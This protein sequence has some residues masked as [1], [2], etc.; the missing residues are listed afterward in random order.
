MNLK[1]SVSSGAKCF[2]VRFHKQSIR[3]EQRNENTCGRVCLSATATG[4]KFQ[5]TGTVADASVTSPVGISLILTW[6]ER[7]SVHG[8]ECAVTRV[9]IVGPVMEWIENEIAGNTRIRA[10]IECSFIDAIYLRPV[11]TF[12]VPFQSRLHGPAG[13]VSFRRYVRGRRLTTWP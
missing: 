1:G 11:K 8:S 9:G 13:C 4:Y 3:S 5:S 2:P 10:E 6:R 12:L 7:R